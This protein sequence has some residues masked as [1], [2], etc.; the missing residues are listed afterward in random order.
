MDD[1]VLDLTEGQKA[2]KAK[3]PPITKKYECKWSWYLTFASFFLMFTCKPCDSLV[4]KLKCP[5]IIIHN[6]INLLHNVLWFYF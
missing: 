6:S 1:R 2:T 4:G 5:N 3:Y